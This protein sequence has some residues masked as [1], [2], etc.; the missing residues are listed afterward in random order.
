MPK[1]EYEVGYKKPPE[2]TRFQLG[3]SGNPNGR[4]KLQKD[5]MPQ[6]R[7]PE[8]IATIKARIREIDVEITELRAKQAGLETA[9]GIAQGMSPVVEVRRK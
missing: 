7:M 3:K 6:K 2:G 5:V 4:P 1:D 8:V 9:L